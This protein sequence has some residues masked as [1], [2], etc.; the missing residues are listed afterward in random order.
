[1][2]IAE[3]KQMN[4]VSKKILQ[5]IMNTEDI[6]ALSNNL[7]MTLFSEV[8][9]LSMIGKLLAAKI[10]QSLEFDMIISIEEKGSGLAMAFAMAFP[11]KSEANLSR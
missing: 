8:A 10:P 11:G 2:T 4:P 7:E 5:V 6:N 9:T 3:E 1:L